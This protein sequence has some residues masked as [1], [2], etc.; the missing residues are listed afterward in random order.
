MMPDPGPFIME[1]PAPLMMPILDHHSCQF[2]LA[3]RLCH[4]LHPTLKLLVSTTLKRVP[5]HF[6]PTSGLNTDCYKLYIYFVLVYQFLIIEITQLVLQY[7]IHILINCQ[8]IIASYHQRMIV[9]IVATMVSRNASCRKWVMAP[10]K[11][12]TSFVCM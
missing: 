12:G 2:L 9:N 6:R 3:P 8:L 11:H 1:D 7:F 10:I 4:I 5:I